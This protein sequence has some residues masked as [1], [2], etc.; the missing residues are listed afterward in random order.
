[1]SQKD[2]KVTLIMVMSANGKVAQ[3]KFQNS[4]EWNSKEDQ[5][6]F[7]KRIKHIGTIIMGSNTFQATKQHPYGEVKYIILTSNDARFNKQA[8]VE[9][10]SGKVDEIYHTLKDRGLKHVALPGGPNVNSQFF[11]HHLIDEIYL[12]VE[13]VL[14]LTGMNFTDELNKNVK[15]RLENM[16]RIDNSQTILLH[17]TVDKTQTD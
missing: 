15:L 2:L 8:N 3:D 14:L 7:L 10:M 12:T 17:Y 16:T 1:M 11:D 9:F 5:R 6:Q 4:F 13:P